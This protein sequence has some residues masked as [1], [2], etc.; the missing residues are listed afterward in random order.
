MSYI[1]FL[2]FFL[3]R[4]LKILS[5]HLS[6]KIFLLPGVSFGSHINRGIVFGLNFSLWPVII[7]SI[8]FLGVIIGLFLRAFKRG[9]KRAIFGLSLLFCGALSNLIDRIVYGGTI[10]YISFF[11]YSFVNLADGMILGG[12]IILIFGVKNQN[13]LKVQMPNVKSSSNDQMP[14]I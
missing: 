1:I 11:N 13:K 2:I 12:I 10:D 8:I 3:D 4:V 7:L 9:E 5:E 6:G 14:K